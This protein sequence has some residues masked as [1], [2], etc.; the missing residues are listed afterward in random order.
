MKRFHSSRVLFEQR[1]RQSRTYSWAAFLFSNVVT[2]IV[3]QTLV[4]V[5]AFVCWYYPL[6]LWRNAE[7]NGELNE[8][9]GLTF[10]FLWSLMLLFQTVSQMLMTFMPDVATGLNIANLM[11]MLSF[12]FAGILVPPDALPRFWIFMYRATPLSYYMSGIMSTGLSGMRIACKAKDLVTIPA[13]PANMTCGT[14]LEQYLAVSGGSLRN[15]DAVAH[16]QVCPYTDADVLL[17]YFGMRFGDRWWNWG[18]TM[19]YNG[20]NIGLAA[21]LCWLVSSLPEAMTIEIVIP[22]E[23]DSYIDVP[24]K[25]RYKRDLEP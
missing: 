11:F 25:E 16:C 15:P 7:I 5:I 1:E 20:I 19:A 22:M 12:I 21:L 10:L 13:V 3:S 6:G 9:A 17:E 23:T 8:R 4:S 14:Y 18:T 24:T 2:E